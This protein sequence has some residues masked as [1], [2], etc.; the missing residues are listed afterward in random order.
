MRESAGVDPERIV[1]PGNDELEISTLI[2]EYW[3]RD[4]EYS[5]PCIMEAFCAAVGVV[6]N[7]A[8]AFA[9]ALALRT[10][11]VLPR[12]NYDAARYA[13]GPIV[14]AND[15]ES[16]D[17]AARLLRRFVADYTTIDLA[18]LGYDAPAAPC[19]TQLGPLLAEAFGGV[20]PITG[21][22]ADLVASG[23]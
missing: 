1:D 3:P 15:H 18:S 4:G 12:G 2:G 10:S 5:G 22:T 23:A 19:G 21:H 6:P 9:F 14:T 7:G 17:E 13:I 20:E 16:L 8:D 11:G